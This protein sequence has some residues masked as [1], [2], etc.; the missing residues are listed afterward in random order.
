LSGVL[1]D[2]FWASTPGAAAITAAAE[3]AIIVVLTFLASFLG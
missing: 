3:S 2:T 1:F